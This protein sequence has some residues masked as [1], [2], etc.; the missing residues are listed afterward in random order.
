MV[1]F[2][3]KACQNF[4]VF[5]VLSL[6]CLAC[7]TSSVCIKYILIRDCS[8]ASDKRNTLYKL[9]NLCELTKVSQISNFGFSHSK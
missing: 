1:T 7:V 2:W 6:Y 3:K 8:G 4:K 5:S 9:N